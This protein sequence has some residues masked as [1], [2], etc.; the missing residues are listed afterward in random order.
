MPDTRWTI[1]VARWSLWPAATPAAPDLGFI[2]PLT[3][4]RL[5]T[6]S[7]AA[8]KVAHD[9]VAHV[10]AVRL[11]FASRH[12]ELGRTTEILHT[13]DAGKTVSPTSFSL[14]VLNTITGVFGIVRGD[15]APASA[16]SAGTETLGYALLEAYA[17]Y[18]TDPSAP[19]L[20]VYADEPADSAY[21]TVEDEVDGGALAILLDSS[22]QT[23][24]LECARA[25]VSDETDTALPGT[26]FSS[27]SHAVQHCLDTRTASAWRGKNSTWQWSWHEAA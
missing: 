25:T 19:V 15:R 7:R 12:G 1:P 26:T 16:L 9:C 23:G 11:V 8:L 10:P 14:S 18:V 6:L 27:Q 22:A 20:L 4:R 3:R 17:Q 2:E 24:H 21:G 13:I 5:S